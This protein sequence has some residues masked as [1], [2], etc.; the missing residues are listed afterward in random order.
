MRAGTLKPAQADSP[1]FN[2]FCHGRDGVWRN[3]GAGKEDKR[4]S[5]FG[6]VADIESG[7][8]VRHTLSD[9]DLLADL[10][11][12]WANEEDVPPQIPSVGSRPPVRGFPQRI[13]AL[14]CH[15]LGSPVNQHRRMRSEHMDRRRRSP[16]LDC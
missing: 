6:S 2:D 3:K 9:L 7:Y 8:C 4:W 14:Y 10:D 16:Q 12:A 5:I 13:T 1:K 15:C 11:A